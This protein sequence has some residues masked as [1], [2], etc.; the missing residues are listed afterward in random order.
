MKK[1]AKNNKYK[2]DESIPISDDEK[3]YVGDSLDKPKP[4]K[5]DSP[6]ILRITKKKSQNPFNMSEYSPKY[7]QNIEYKKDKDKDFIEITLKNKVDKKS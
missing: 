2:F 7:P 1:M 5:T 3:D 4:V 6:K